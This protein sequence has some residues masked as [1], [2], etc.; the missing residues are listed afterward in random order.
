MLTVSETFE[1][2]INLSC[3]QRRRFDRSFYF[4]PDTGFTLNTLVLLDS[5]RVA[6]GTT[7]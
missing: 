1:F 3:S 4:M 2:H 5:Q 7:L 6:S